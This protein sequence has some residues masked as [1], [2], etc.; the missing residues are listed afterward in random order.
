VDPCAGESRCNFAGPFAAEVIRVNKTVT[1]PYND[2]T[3]DVTI[4]FSNLTTTPLILGYQSGSSIM[5]DDAGNRYLW[6]RPGTHDGSARGIGL[7]TGSAADPSFQIAPGKSRDAT[8]KVWFRAGRRQVGTSYAYDVTIVQL[9]ILP[10][11]QIR[12]VREFAVGFQDL[13]AGRW[14]GAK[15]VE[16]LLGDLLK[17]ATKPNP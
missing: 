9:E 8:F 7:V 12:E 11:K 5:V 1:P 13:N 16:G 4:R 14:G 3:L 17:A 15:S 2:N 10:S 6:G